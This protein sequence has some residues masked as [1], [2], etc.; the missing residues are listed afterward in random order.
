MTLISTN[1]PSQSLTNGLINRVRLLG[2]LIAVTI[3]GLLV[4]SLL[5]AFQSSRANVITVATDAAKRIDLFLSNLETDLSAV[6]RTFTLT[7]EENRTVILRDILE[8]YGAIFQ[9]SMVSNDGEVLFDRRRVGA[10]QTG[11]YVDQ[12]WQGQT[13]NGKVYLSPIDYSEFGVPTAIVGLPVYDGDE[14]TGALVAKLELTGL[15]SLI[16]SIQVGENGYAYL[17]DDTGRLLAYRDVALVQ[18]NQTLQQ[19]IGQSSE[20]LIGNDTRLVGNIY[21]GLA[22]NAVLAST[23]PLSVVDWVAVVEVPII[24]SLLPLVPFAALMLLIVGVALYVVFNINNYTLQRI[25]N[26]LKRLNAGV[27]QI[28]QGNLTH[29]IPTV[30]SSGD[31]IQV[32]ALTLNS[33]TEQLYTLINGLEERV[34]VR[35][36]DIEVAANVSAK[37]TSL[38]DL[39]TLLGQIVELIRESFGFE[40]V[41]ILLYDPETHR[42]NLQS[43]SGTASKALMAGDLSFHIDAP[44]V[45]NRSAR[46]QQTVVV[47][48]VNSSPD[49]MPHPAMPMIQAE[50]AIPFQLAG[51]LIGVLDIESNERGRFD[52]NELQALKTLAEQIA[53]AVE[54]A[55][56]YT[57]QQQ[58]IK[59]LQIAD[60]VKSQFLASM[61]HELRTPLNAILNFT[62]FNLMGIYGE[63]TARQRDSM[64]KILGSAQHLLELINDVLDIAKIEA[65]MMQLFIEGDIDLNAELATVMASGEALLAY[66]SQNVQL[67]SDI[68]ANL[69]LV[70]GDRRRIRQIILN[71]VSNACKF[72]E[73]GTVTVSA[74]RRGD[75]VHI[76]VL[77]TGPGIPTD[78]LDIIFEPFQQTETGIK[79]S[80]GTGL[81]LP[82]AK[83]LIEAHHGRLS[84][85]STLGEGSAFYV[86]LPV[87]A[88][89]LIALMQPQEVMPHV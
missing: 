47:N 39:D 3:L 21:S 28:R 69:P 60:Q 13:L 64:E 22:G 11:V 19:L 38:R 66:K 62:R 10:S 5:V 43:T 72:T 58:L 12:P 79:H 48:D 7:A 83:R 6:G 49:Y 15:W 85:E 56:L 89:Q 17:V 75:D 16:V 52:D 86:V 14:V 50:L 59:D 2:A 27:D 25:V 29:E 70:I 54:N 67:I 37:I 8:R 32:L 51:Q 63:L 46:M 55:R 88:P 36:R 87:R 26:P 24:E 74:K 44:G 4:V 41:S 76:A 61:S 1:T 45:I 73:D 84:V 68:D 80:G 30:G 23:E 42:L 81:G 40:Q 34:A 71:L 82:I 57:R 77:D 18:Q 33:V 31:E 65:D 9:I 35:T 78:K 20:Q 53:V